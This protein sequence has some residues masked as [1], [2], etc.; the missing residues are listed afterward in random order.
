MTYDDSVYEDL[1]AMNI[2]VLGA[3]RQ[4]LAAYKV[5]AQTNKDPFDNLLISI[6][7]LHGYQL[8]TSDGPIQEVQSPGLAVINAQK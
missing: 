8:V 1:E 5:H 3:D 6:A 2:R 4:T 7:I